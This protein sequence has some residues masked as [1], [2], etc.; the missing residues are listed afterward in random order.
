VFGNGHQTD[1]PG[2][3]AKAGDI[4]PEIRKVAA[5]VSAPEIIWDNAEPGASANTSFI[6]DS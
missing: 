1:L 3:E 4:K 5:T 6:T 2:Y